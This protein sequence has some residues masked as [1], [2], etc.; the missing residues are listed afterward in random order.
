M[1][2]VRVEAFLMCDAVIVDPVSK[3]P[4][5]Q[6]IFDELYFDS[7]PAAYERNF[8]VFGRLRLDRPGSIEAEIEVQT[9]S[10]RREKVG[11]P[12][13]LN[14]AN[15]QV[16]GLLTPGQRFPVPEVGR[17]VISLIVDGKRISDF[18]VTAIKVESTAAT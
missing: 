5:V 16:I 8:M 14:S 17:Y 4:T 15:T 10:G 18:H 9:P 11:P 13:Q 1:P 2:N 3:K 6:G 7:F 12:M